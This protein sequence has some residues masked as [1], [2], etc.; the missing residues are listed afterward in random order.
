M[1]T[2]DEHQQE[3]A[4]EIELDPERFRG[5][6]RLRWQYDEVVESVLFQYGPD[7]DATLTLP[8]ATAAEIV[9]WTK[10]GDSPLTAWLHEVERR[11]ATDGMRDAGC[12]MRG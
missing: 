3:W 9:A 4:Y 6:W 7:P 1:S 11:D 12:G 8:Y 2:R 5:D 10:A